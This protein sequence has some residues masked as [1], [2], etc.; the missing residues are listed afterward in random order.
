M[1]E[2]TKVEPMPVAAQM[3]NVATMLQTV[4]AHGITEQNVA[5][6]DKLCGLLER[7]QEKEAERAF[8]EAFVRLQS[9]IPKIQATKSVPNNDGSVRYTFAPFEEIDSQ[10]R[11]ICLR[12]GFSYSFGEAASEP[13][14][15]TKVF[16]LQHVGGHKRSNSYTVRIGKGP[17][18]CSESQADGSAHSYSKRGAMCDGLCIVVRGQDSDARLEGDCITPAQV[19]ALKCRVADTHTNEAKFLKFAQA[20]RYEEIKAFMFSPC[21]Q[22]LKRREEMI[23]LNERASKP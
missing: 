11:P 21:D 3:P 16:T 14:K 6:V 22:E 20:S 13:G 23:I 18:G 2:L 9:K 7:M 19:T 17:P 5:A 8:A 10:A 15:L 4:L 1:N 12:N